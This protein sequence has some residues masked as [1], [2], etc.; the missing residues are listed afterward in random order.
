M[1][2]RVA[3]I[4]ILGLM[5]VNHSTVLDMPRKEHRKHER[6]GADEAAFAPPRR[7]QPAGVGQTMR[8]DRAKSGRASDPLVAD[9]IRRCV[10]FFRPHLRCRDRGHTVA[11]LLR[12]VRPGMASARRGFS[13]STRLATSSLR[14]FA[15]SGL[16]PATD[17]P[18]PG[19]GP[20]PSSRLHAVRPAGD[21]ALRQMARRSHRAPPPA[22]AGVP[23]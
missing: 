16:D 5:Y 21:S 15:L 13:R 4:K 20:Q 9:W 23:W 10:G 1:K 19:P 11:R 14:P 6:R 7:D 18:A 12:A 22:A 2:E 17:R 8:A 3:I